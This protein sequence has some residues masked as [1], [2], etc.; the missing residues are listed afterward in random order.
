MSEI[1]LNSDPEVTDSPQVEAS[2]LSEPAISAIAPF[3]ER[4]LLY[5]VFLALA[6]MVGGLSN[7]CIKQFLLPAQIG[8]LDPLHKAT[9]LLI[10]ASIGAVAGMFAAPITG[11]LSDRSIRRSG[12]RR[13]WIIAGI[14]VASGG[15]LTMAFSPTIGFIV[16]GEILA[17][18]GV[19][20]ILAVT[21]AL[22]PDQVPA[23]QQWLVTALVGIAPNVGGVIGLL[24]VTNFTNVRIPWQ[25]YLLMTIVSLACIG[26]FLLIVQ[27]DQPREQ[28]ELPP[29]HLGHFL[30]GFA[31]PL[32]VAD[33]RY[34]FL[35][36]FLAYLAFTILGNY[37]LYYLLDRLSLPL[38]VAAGRLT[39]FQLLST[40]VL[41]LASVLAGWLVQKRWGG[42]LK[43]VVIVGAGCMAV[44]LF[45]MAF[46]PFWNTLLVAAAIFGL[47]FGAYLGVDVALAM[48]AL[49][50]TTDSGK[51]LGLMYTAIFLA[52]AISPV[53]GAVFLDLLHSHLLLF[54][55]AGVASLLAALQILPI[56]SVQ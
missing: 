36:R 11:A 3:R 40:A 7:V 47:G 35:S 24:L 32:A 28:E 56:K 55:F 30:I 20:T 12:K 21:T 50:T 6:V 8:G 45:L 31:R 16:I 26:L 10:V 48:A 33:F 41:F 34:T 29:F 53:A 9:S 38:P 43:P 42:R 44:G 46:F 1:P 18:V 19:D 25:G 15:M 13:P 14:L 2:V 5:R 17:Q 37:T 4:S 54:S 51:N 52:L 22:I 49:P 27:E 39:M 23:R